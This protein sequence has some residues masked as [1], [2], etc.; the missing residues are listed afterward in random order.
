ME[1]NSSATTR[2]APAK[3]NLT[4]EVGGKRPDG[5]HNL[6]SIVAP[7]GLSDLVAIDLL[8]S[9]SKRSCKVFGSA[10]S[11]SQCEDLSGEN[12]LAFR[13][14]ELL[15]GLS[16]ATRS[17]G[18]HIEIE[19]RIPLEAGLGG[20]SSDA[21]AV[22]SLLTSKLSARLNQI[23]TLTEPLL[24]MFAEKIGSDVPCMIN[25]GIKLV[26]GRGEQL[27]EIRLSDSAIKFF[28]DELQV[29][30]IKP[31]RGVATADAYSWLGRRGDSQPLQLSSNTKDLMAL[32]QEE[33]V[34]GEELFEG[35]R[36]HL[37]NDF[38]EVVASR[39]REVRAILDAAGAVRGI[40]PLLSGSGSTVLIFGY[41]SHSSL[42]RLLA[43][44]S[45]QGFFTCDTAIALTG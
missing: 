32:F 26:S 20:G 41:R 36:L 37:R 11:G 17:L 42:S 27:S 2:A 24:L 5:Y 22:I 23:S 13:A 7:L 12:N 45:E 21:A 25:P 30:L 40:F 4:L 28:K 29:G 10:L 8:E 35:L 3:I 14:A 6:Q 18:F 1:I 31:P 15:L 16:P 33:E 44:F 9:S 38:Q 39:H 43:Q 34:G 19:K